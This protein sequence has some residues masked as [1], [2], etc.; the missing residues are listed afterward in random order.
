MQTITP[1]SDYTQLL[2]EQAAAG[3]AKAVENLL[4]R[5]RPALRQAVHRRLDPRVKPRVDPS[6]VV[7]ETQIEAANRLGEFLRSRPMPFRLWL[8]KTAHERMK[9]IER[10]HLETAKRAMEKQ[11]PLPANTSLHLAR[12]LIARGLGPAAHASRAE[13][14]RKIRLMLGSLSE[15]DCEIIMLRNFEELSNDEV[16][17]VLDI[18]PETARKRYVRA[19]V[20]LQQLA[21]E[22]GLSEA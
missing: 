12:G 1:D 8:L 5:H 22:Q 13:V 19:L 6:D 18:Q 14:I 17:C 3:E 11:V 15:T 9:K 16:A 2:L 20:R 10:H 21:V 4:A 7:Q